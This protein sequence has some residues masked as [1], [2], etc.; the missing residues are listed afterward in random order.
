MIQTFLIKYALSLKKI[1]NGEKDKGKTIIIATPEIKLLNG[2]NFD[3]IL[4]IENE[5]IV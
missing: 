4:N 3:K 5:R 1:L 2:L